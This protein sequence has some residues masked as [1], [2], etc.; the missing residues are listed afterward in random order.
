MN[1]TGQSLFNV[2]GETIQLRTTTTGGM[3]STS[4]N[5]GITD[6]S[7]NLD[8][9]DRNPNYFQN[10]ECVWERFNPNQP[11][12]RTLKGA[13]GITVQSDAPTRDIEISRGLT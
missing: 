4:E 9:D 6:I 13:G 10:G 3:S 7:S 2:N 11:R 5:L 8:I 1:A 12:F